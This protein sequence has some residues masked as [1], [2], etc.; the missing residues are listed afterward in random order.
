M[1]FTIEPLSN[2]HCHTGEN[3]YWHPGDQCVYW[4]DIPAGVLY[5]Y[6][7]TN[8]QTEVVYRGPQVG[9]F[10]LQADG[11]FL[12]F[13]ES[14]IAALDV[15]SMRVETIIEYADETMT[16]FNDVHA[17]PLGRVYAGTISMD[18]KPIGSL[19]CVDLDGSVRKVATGSAVGNGLAFTPDEKFLYWTCS[20]RRRIFRFEWDRRTGDLRNEIA[21]YDAPEEEGIPDGMAMDE[22]GNL[23]SCRWD[24]SRIVVIDPYGKLIDTIWFDV[25]K[26]SSAIFGGKNHNELFVTTAGGNKNSQTADGTL[27]RIVTQTRGRPRFVSRIGLE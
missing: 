22:L 5:R 2:Q 21:F 4:T 17:D 3:P 13:R 24:G 16:R 15:N 10:T 19:Y 6:D 25:E 12:L 9:G 26:V 7:P 8:K 11:K 1:S 23:W 14:D 20:S 18:R 27:Y